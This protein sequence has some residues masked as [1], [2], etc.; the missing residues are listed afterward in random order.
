MGRNFYKQDSRGVAICACFVLVMASFPLGAATRYDGDG[1]LSDRQEYVRWRINRA[2]FIP[3]READRLGLTNSATGGHPN[4]DV[5][6]DVAL[7]NDF[8]STTNEWAAWLLTMQPLAPNAL[9][10]LSA[11][12]H[13]DDM[14][15]E[16]AFQHATPSGSPS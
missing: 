11:D 5:A 16:D 7:P 13:V 2:R 4:Y 3:E 6:E 15:R 12:R 8:G 10:S 9:L 1:V 14:V